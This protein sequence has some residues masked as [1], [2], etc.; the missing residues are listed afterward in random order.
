ML[1]AINYI[2]NM[3]IVHRCAS[4]SIFRPHAQELHSCYRIPGPQKG[5]RRVSEGVSEGVFEGFLKGSAEG[6]FK[7]PS[8]TPSKTLQKPFRNPFRDPSGVWGS[9]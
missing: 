8:R 6:P 2:H 7:T 5:F 1:L 4:A 9:L 3:G